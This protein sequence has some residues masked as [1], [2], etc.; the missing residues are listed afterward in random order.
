MIT[1]EEAGDMLDEIATEIPPEFYQELNGG[2]LL[3]PEEKLHPEAVSG[4]MYILG[5]YNRNGNMGRYI[6]LYYGSFQKL[7][8]HLAP[9]QFRQKLKKTL[10]HEFTHHW[11]S[12]AGERDLEIKD[13]IQMEQYRRRKEQS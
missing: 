8:G 2:V 11:E 3:L 9:D 4:D 12:L 6:V 10:L 1:F 13:A 5:E 7:H